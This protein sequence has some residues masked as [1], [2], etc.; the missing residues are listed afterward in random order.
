MDNVKRTSFD[1]RGIVLSGLAIVAAIGANVLMFCILAVARTMPSLTYPEDYEPV[2]VIRL[3]LPAPTEVE[4][5]G[6]ESIMDVIQL[7]PDQTDAE[8]PQPAAEMV[9]S[10]LPR[11][12]ERIWGVSFEL[13][14]LPV[15]SSRVSL[16]SP[17]RAAP[18]GGVDKPV[19]APK[20]DRL[21]SKIAGPPPR[22]P[23]WA[24][25]DH[26]EAVVTLRF[27]VTAEGTVE[28]VHIHDIEGDERFGDEAARAVRQWR[29]R[30]A[31]RAGSPVPCWCFQKINFEF[32]PRKGS[33]GGR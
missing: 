12:A 31:M 21:P 30:P 5:A 6:R 14:G 29:F 28:D 10:A 27:I 19:S 22:Y 9:S 15:R 33:P 25:R 16:L 1:G 8:T 7:G 32:T 23:Q 13:P 11:L 17:T 3:D 18:V 24:R 26:L 2:R 4:P 20:V